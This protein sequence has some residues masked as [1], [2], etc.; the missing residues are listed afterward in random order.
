MLRYMSLFC[1]IWLFSINAYA[2]NGPSLTSECNKILER[3]PGSD[4]GKKRTAQLYKCVQM[5]TE[6]SAQNYNIGEKNSAL[7]SGD[8]SLF[9]RPT[10]YGPG[11]SSYPK[12][13]RFEYENF[14]YS[15]SADGYVQLTGLM[16]GCPSQSV[17]I[18]SI[19]IGYRPK[20]TQIFANYAGN[21]TMGMVIVDPKGDVY[22][23]KT[24]RDGS[25]SNGECD[26][27]PIGQKWLSLA[28]LRFHIS[29]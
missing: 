11:W 28:G 18:F 24:E 20:S 19:P 17:P 12:G 8:K 9:I 15:K 26:K 13:G 23:W 22:L 1:A 6:L 3:F 10:S 14:Q 4:Q 5:L 16:S 7:I 27:L 2:Q 29:N 25:N 21:S